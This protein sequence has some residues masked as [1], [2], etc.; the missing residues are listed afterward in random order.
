MKILNKHNKTFFTNKSKIDNEDLEAARAVLQK[1]IL[2]CQKYLDQE[3]TQQK[4]QNS[5]QTKIGQEVEKAL[6]LSLNEESLNKFTQ[7]LTSM[8]DDFEIL[9][10]NKTNL[11]PPLN[12]KQSSSNKQEHYIVYTA[13]H[14]PNNPGQGS[15]SYVSENTQ[16][17]EI[18]YA[19]ETYEFTT[20]NR[21][22]I[23]PVLESLKQFKESASI[24]FITDSMYVIKT[25]KE[26]INLMSDNNWIKE[27]GTLYANYDLWQQI[28]KLMQSHNISI[29]YSKN[30]S[31]NQYYQECDTLLEKAFNLDMLK[32]DSGFQAFI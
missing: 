6:D 5:F 9:L 7:F 18:N 23:M 29:Q 31:V 8:K 24:I 10:N 16:T 17:K 3:Q 4:F 13:G 19:F 14:V 2:E 25:L 15:W 27:D 30:H 32:I 11:E 1:E 28:Y 21:M 26:R 20:R 12:K 22:K